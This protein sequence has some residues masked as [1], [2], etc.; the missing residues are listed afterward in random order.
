MEQ[1]GCVIAGK[2]LATRAPQKH[3]A[4]CVN[5]SENMV[6]PF[7]DP[8]AA[9]ASGARALMWCWELWRSCSP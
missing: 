9:Q 8:L 6:P 1:G 3:H 7:P 4:I 2:L 5:Q